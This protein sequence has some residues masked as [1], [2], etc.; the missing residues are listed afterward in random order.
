MAQK[1][2]HD[3]T[4]QMDDV[5]GENPIEQARMKVRLMPT[6]AALLI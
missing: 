3:A 4:D 6:A 1:Q 5:E 2:V